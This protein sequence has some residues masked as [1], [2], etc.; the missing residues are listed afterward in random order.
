MQGPRRRLVQNRRV[1]HSDEFKRL[2]VTKYLS[3]GSR[4]VA[5]VTAELG[6]APTMIYEWVN[7]LC[8]EDRVLRPVSRPPASLSAP[9]KLKI[10][11]EYEALPEAE[12]G[13]FLRANGV[14]SEQIAQWKQTMT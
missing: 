13:E 10:V 1:K 11:L 12:R 5:D 6:I 7:K 2:A 9:E 4:P 3:R 8:D 14:T